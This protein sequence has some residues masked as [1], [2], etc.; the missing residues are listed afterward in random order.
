[1]KLIWTEELVEFIRK[2]AGEDASAS[3]IAAD[4]GGQG[5]V[6]T[7]NA[8]VG[9]CHRSGISLSGDGGANK[10]T[11]SK[12]AQRSPRIRK[13]ALVTAPSGSKSVVVPKQKPP[14]TRFAKS[15]SSNPV[16]IGDLKDSLCRWPMGGFADRPPYFYC[17]DPAVEGCSWCSQHQQIA[18]KVTFKETSNHVETKRVV[19]A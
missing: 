8:V 13:P 5:Y 17:G 6:V 10:R 3:Q 19:A 7:R 14:V 2:R 4:L 18:T 1:M 12:R 15:R 11:S 9:K 16:L